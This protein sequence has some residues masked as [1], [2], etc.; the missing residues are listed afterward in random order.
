MKHYKKVVINPYNNKQEI[1]ILNAYAEI[2]IHLDEV[3][4]KKKKKNG[5]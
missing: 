5:K 1:K 4:L 3:D 2:P